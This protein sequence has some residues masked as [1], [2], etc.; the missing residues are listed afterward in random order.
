MRLAHSA[1]FVRAVFPDHVLGFPDGRVQQ[2]I[3]IESGHGGGFTDRY[4]W[5]MAIVKKK[6]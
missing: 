4:T 3:N 1:V 2:T 5:Q 6:I